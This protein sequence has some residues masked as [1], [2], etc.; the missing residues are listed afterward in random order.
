MEK[1]LSIGFYNTPPLWVNTQFGV[2]QF[3]FPYLDFSNL[4]IRSIP[5]KLRLGHQ[6]EHLFDQ[7]LSHSNHWEILAKNVIVDEGKVRV[8][9]LDFILEN[10]ID[11]KA[12]HVELAY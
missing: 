11:K 12:Y 9:E 2:S 6:M 1:E 4:T 3:D 10:K 5:G 7:L 8:G